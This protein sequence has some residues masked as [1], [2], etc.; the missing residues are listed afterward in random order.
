MYWLRQ[1]GQT[2]RFAHVSE[3]GR[4][5]EGPEVLHNQQINQRPQSLQN[6]CTLVSQLYS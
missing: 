1:K 4:L 3:A 2:L 6:V 5:S